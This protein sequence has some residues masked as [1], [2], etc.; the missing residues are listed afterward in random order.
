MERGRHA[1]L[2]D[3]R[4]KTEAARS[5]ERNRLTDI[6]VCGD[7]VTRRTVYWIKRSPR[8]TQ[9]GSD[10]GLSVIVRKSGPNMGDNGTRYLGHL[11][12]RSNLIFA[13]NADL[14]LPVY[15]HSSRGYV[16]L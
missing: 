12:F 1:E 6:A 14:V 7:G 4:K 11:R 10:S 9:H 5:I 2:I 15:V 8:R 13:L 16:L 3:T